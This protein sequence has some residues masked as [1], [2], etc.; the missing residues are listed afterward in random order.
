MEHNVVIWCD[1]PV[2]CKD[3][4][5][6][7]YYGDIPVVNYNKITHRFEPVENRRG[8]AYAARGRYKYR[9]KI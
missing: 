3:R 8:N 1:V 5:G 4:Y 9:K 6:R 2:V 7:R